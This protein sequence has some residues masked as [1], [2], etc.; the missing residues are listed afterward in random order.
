[1]YSLRSG[2]L[3]LQGL[4]YQLHCM[5]GGLLFFWARPEA[6]MHAMCG[7][8]V[9]KCV[10]CVRMCSMPS[11][12]LQLGDWFEYGLHCLVCAWCLF[13]GIGP[14]A[15]LQSLRARNIRKQFGFYGVHNMLEWYICGRLWAGA[16]L[17]GGFHL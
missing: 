7:R 5:F 1:M 12:D 2:G 9:F 14:Q 10:K 13:L 17:E 6:S 4:K 8:H 16:M 11:R 15:G 3:C